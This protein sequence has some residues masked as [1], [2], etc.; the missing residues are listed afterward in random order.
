[1]RIKYKYGQAMLEFAVILPFFILL[2]MGFVYTGMVFHDY[3]AIGDLTR[4]V[5]RYESVG[6][7]YNDIKDDLKVDQRMSNLYD[8]NTGADIKVAT[9]NEGNQLGDFV[10]VTVTA[11]RKDS[12]NS[13][14]NYVLPEKLTTSL[15][16]RKEV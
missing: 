2:L 16:M 12:E 5:A 8:V 11:K 9:A 10:T 4:D 1:M 3:L 14:L 7:K 13:F 6:I 15:S